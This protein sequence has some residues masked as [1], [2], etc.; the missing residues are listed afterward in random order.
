[1]FEKQKSSVILLAIVKIFIVYK[2]KFSKCN[3]NCKNILNDTSVK[4]NM[5]YFTPMLFF[6]FQGELVHILQEKKL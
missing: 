3:A 4:N 2:S 6:L 5:R 1:M